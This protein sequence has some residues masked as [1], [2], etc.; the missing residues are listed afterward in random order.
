[1]K[2]LFI[3]VASGSGLLVC[4]I[5][6]KVVAFQSIDHRISDSE[7]LRVVKNVLQEACWKYMD[8]AHIACVIGPGGFTSLRVGVSFANALG[9]VLGIPVAGVHL[10][11][12]YAARIRGQRKFNSFLWLHST[13][14]HEL[15]VRGFGK[16]ARKWPKPVCMEIPKFLKTLRGVHIRSLWWVGELLPEHKQVLGTVGAWHGST[17][18]TTGAMPLQPLQRVLPTFLGFL[19]YKKQVLKPWYGRTW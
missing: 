3:D 10:S 13:R 9:A 16:F 14:K 2:C 6:K 8:I 15:F 5:E 18:L 17:E 7:L 11:D 1:M 19:K 12:L 4:A